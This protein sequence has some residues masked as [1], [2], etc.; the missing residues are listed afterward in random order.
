MLVNPLEQSMENVTIHVHKEEGTGGHWCA[1][2]IFF[3]LFTVLI[4]LIGVII[5]EYRGTTDVDT[6]IASSRWA[7]IFEGWVDETPPSHEGESHDVNKHDDHDEEEDDEG[8]GSEIEENEEDAEDENENINDADEEAFN[9]RGVSQ[10]IDDEEEDDVDESENDEG[11]EDDNDDDENEEEDIGVLD[12]VEDE[13]S[14]ENEDE[15]QENVENKDSNEDQEDLSVPDLNVSIEG[16]NPSSVE[17]KDDE[18]EYEFVGIPGINKIDDDS[19]EPLEEIEED[20]QEEVINEIEIEVEPSVDETMEEESTSVAVKFG[21]GVALVV[22]AHFVLVRRWN[23][24]DADLVA[25]T[26]EVRDLSRRNTIVPPANIKQLILTGD[27]SQKQQQGQ[28]VQELNNKYK[29]LQSENNQMI[30]NKFSSQVGSQKI[31]KKEWDSTAANQL[32]RKES[33]EVATSESER[34]SGT[35]NESDYDYDEDELDDE[36]V[37]EEEDVEEEEEEDDEEEELDDS[38][39]VAKL[40]AKYG[41]LA[42]PSQSEE[43]EEEE[44]EE[45]EEEE[46]EDER[47]EEGIESWKRLNAPKNVHSSG[48]DKAKDSYKPKESTKIHQKSSSASRGGQQAADVVHP[49][50]HNELSFQEEIE[51]WLAGVR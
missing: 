28:N 16:I 7:T 33:Q 51:N 21:V 31:N 15:E 40:E 46:E 6:P 26:D 5:F 18:F 14:I 36:E 12:E 32:K 20:E 4:G 19:A 35:E 44:E 42:T 30:K 41:K 24:V 3:A 27:A 11:F 22:A 50:D 47:K 29:D 10:E 48:T 17:K 43:E 37:D 34:F 49:E 1:R 45:S 2:I 9:S 39:L 13:E 8:V 38:E 25:Y 23:N